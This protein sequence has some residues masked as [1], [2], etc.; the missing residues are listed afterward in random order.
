MTTIRRII[1]FFWDH[2]WRVRSGPLFDRLPVSLHLCHRCGR[3]TFK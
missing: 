3:L 1:C 2:D